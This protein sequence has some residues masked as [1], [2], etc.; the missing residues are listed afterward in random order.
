MSSNIPLGEATG[1]LVIVFD[2]VKTNAG[3][4]HPSTGVFIVP[5]SGIYVFSWTLRNGENNFH[6]TELVVSNSV[7]SIIQLHSAAGIWISGTG[8]AVLHVNKGDGVCVRISAVGHYGDI[9]SDNFGKSS[10]T[11]WKLN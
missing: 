7:E 2:V 10:F 4:D 1:N 11:G 5:E 8:V 9:H 3:N 6:S